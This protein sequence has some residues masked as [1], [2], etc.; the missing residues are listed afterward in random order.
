MSMVNSL[1]EPNTLYYGEFWLNKNEKNSIL[2]P[3]NSINF[4]LK[5]VSISP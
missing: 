3:E 5:I 2:Q 4:T 1:L